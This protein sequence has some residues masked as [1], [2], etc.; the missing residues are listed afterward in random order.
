MRCLWRWADRKQSLF[1]EYLRSADENHS[2]EAQK[3]ESDVWK[4]KSEKCREQCLSTAYRAVWLKDHKSQNQLSAKL[5]L[6][7][8]ILLKHWEGQQDW[9]NSDWHLNYQS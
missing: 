6:N 7:K 1:V 5:K 9:D 2:E 8:Q 4:K 3:N